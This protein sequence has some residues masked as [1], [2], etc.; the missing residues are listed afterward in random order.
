[1]HNGKKAHAFVLNV[2]IN[3]LVLCLMICFSTSAVAR[4]EKSPSDERL[5]ARPHAGAPYIFDAMALKKN[6]AVAFVLDE[7][8]PPNSCGPHSFEIMNP[9][10]GEPNCVGVN[11]KH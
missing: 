1:L 9:D 2:E 11:V 6:G 3:V 8:A 5:S 4:S 7:P 10:P